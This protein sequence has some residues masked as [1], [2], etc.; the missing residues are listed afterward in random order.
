MTPRRLPSCLGSSFAA[1]AAAPPLAAASCCLSSSASC[2][3]ASAGFGTVGSMSGRMAALRSAGVTPSDC[4]SWK[5]WPWMSVAP[6]AFPLFYACQPE[7][8]QSPGGGLLTL[9]AAEETAEAALAAP[10]PCAAAAALDAA[11]PARWAAVP[12]TP[13][14]GLRPVTRFQYPPASAAQTVNRQ[15]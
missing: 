3:A 13:V 12:P 2:R 7:R 6:E 5:I 8:D 14:A 4:A 1:A 9:P 11:L 15:T 10:P